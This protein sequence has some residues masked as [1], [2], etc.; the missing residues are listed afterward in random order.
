M[1]RGALLM[2]EEE[3]RICNKFKDEEELYD[4]CMSGRLYEAARGLVDSE[5]SNVAHDPVEYME[6]MGWD[7][8]DITPEIA[9]CI[10]LE[11][12]FDEEDVILVMEK[13][14]EKAAEELK[15]EKSEDV[16]DAVYH[17]SFEV[18]DELSNVAARRLL[19]AI[20]KCKG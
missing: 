12:T 3:E 10:D 8:S 1:F 11:I 13:L 16:F 6:S 4:Y 18:S 2:R 5:I 14:G 19:E 7:T 15:K 17:A 20:K 9:E